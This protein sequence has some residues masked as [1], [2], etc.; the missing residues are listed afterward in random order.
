MI[1]VYTP[2]WDDSFVSK[3]LRDAAQPPLWIPVE[4]RM[5]EVRQRLHEGCPPAIV[6]A[7]TEMTAFTM[8]RSLGFT[9]GRATFNASLAQYHQNIFNVPVPAEVMDEHD[10]KTKN[11]VARKKREAAKASQNARGRKWWEHR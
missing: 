2:S 11:K 1:I 4:W 3:W 10:P 6:T 9:T 8:N 5:D 7:G